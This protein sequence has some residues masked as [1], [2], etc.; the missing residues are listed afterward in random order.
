MGRC[1]AN[2][3]KKLAIEKVLPDIIFVS[4]PSIE[5]TAN[6]VEYANMKK[7]SL[8]KSDKLPLLHKKAAKNSDPNKLTNLGIG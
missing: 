6:V 3:F 2:G 7:L 5:I 8:G 1:F 4:M